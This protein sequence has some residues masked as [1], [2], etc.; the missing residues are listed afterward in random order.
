MLQCDNLLQDAGFYHYKEPEI[1][2]NSPRAVEIQRINMFL[3]HSRQ[4][5]CDILTRYVNDEPFISCYVLPANKTLSA[6]SLNESSLSKIHVDAASDSVTSERKVSLL[7]NTKSHW[8]YKLEASVLLNILAVNCEPEQCLFEMP[9]SRDDRSD[10]KTDKEQCLFEMPPT[11]RK[12]DKAQKEI[13]G[14]KLHRYF[15]CDLAK[16]LLSEHP[17]L[18]AVA[19][20]SVRIA[21]Q[22]HRRTLIPPYRLETY[23]DPCEIRNIV[24]AA[25]ACSALRSPS[26]PNCC[27]LDCAFSGYEGT[28]LLAV[29]YSP[30]SSLLPASQTSPSALFFSPTHRPNLESRLGQQQLNRLQTFLHEHMVRIVETA[31]CEHHSSINQRLENVETFA[32]ESLSDSLVQMVQF[33]FSR[34]SK[35]I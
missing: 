33:R 35:C 23:T 17:H 12:T 20:A 28:S 8:S 1:A 27:F 18:R 5:L 30:V 22:Y 31:L 2:G 10:R 16:Q 32:D 3:L 4:R 7:E 24:S 34:I 6:A 19:I 14:V 11:D 21:L 25:L 26:D 15:V 29:R 9:S 13:S